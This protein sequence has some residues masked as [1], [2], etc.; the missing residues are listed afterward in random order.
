MNVMNTGE[1]HQI[2]SSE[3]KRRFE[4]TL[5]N[6]FKQQNREILENESIFQ[7]KLGDE[8]QEN[9]NPTTQ[10]QFSQF[11]GSGQKPV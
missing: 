6:Y 10:S 9:A 7:M 2:S 5:S 1:K 4:F 11:F 3:K 8:R